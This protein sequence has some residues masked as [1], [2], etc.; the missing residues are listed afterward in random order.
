MSSLP[1]VV[2]SRNGDL[3]RYGG[4]RMTAEAFLAGADG[5]PE[6]GGAVINLCRSWRYLSKGYYVS[7]LAEARGQRVVPAPRELL[8]AQGPRILRA[9]EEA[10]V[11]TAPQEERLRR[12]GLAA[13]VKGGKPPLLVKRAAGAGYEPAPT[14]AVAEPAVLLGRC[15]DPR[16]RRLATVVFRT[17]PLPLLR[18]R[19]VREEKRWKVAAVVPMRLGHLSDEER[20]ELVRVLEGKRA[21]KLAV[22]AERPP[23][24]RAALAVLFEEGDAHLPS[25]PETIERLERVAAPLGLHVHR[26]GLRD[27][28][29]LGDYDALF[30][31]TLTGPDLPSF[32]FALQAESLGMP[33]IDDTTSILRC[34]NKVFLHELL[35]RAGLSTPPTRVVARGTKFEALTRELGRPVVLKLPDGSFASAVFRVEDEAEF[36]RRSGE[37]LERSPLILAQAYTP[38]AFDWRVTTLGGAPLFACKYHMARGHWQIAQRTGSGTH[39][40]RVEAVA[41]DDVPRAVLDLAVR[42]SCLVGGGL[43]GVDLKETPQGAVVIEVNDNPNIDLGYDDAVAGDSVY[44]ALAQHFLQAIEAGFRPGPRR[45][46]AGPEDE[47]LAGWRRPIRAPE[48]AT[49]AAPYQPFEVC[50]LELEYAVVDRD[51]NAVSRVEPALRLLAGR[52]TSDLTLG[53]FGVG[54]EYADHVLELR[55]DVPLRRLRDTEAALHEGIRRVNALL[56]DRLDARLLPTGMHPWLV[57]ARARRWTR[58]NRRIYGTYER[59][60]DTVSHGWVNVQAMH[61]NLPLGAAEADAVALINASALLVPYIPAVAASSPLVEGELTEYVD[62]RLAQLLVHQARL[63]ESTGRLV[64]EPITSL[65]E[66]KRRVVQPMYQ[67]LD[68][69]PDS[70]ALRREF[71][72]VRAAVV[73]SS[74]AALEVRVVDVQECVHMDVALAAFTRWTLRAMSERL[75]RGELEIPAHDALVKDLQATAT[76]GSRARVRAPHVPDVD[77]DAEGLADARDV[78]EALIDWA[79]EVAPEDERAYLDE[80]AEVARQGSLAERIAAALEPLADDEDQF[81]EAARRLYIELADCLLE[82]RPWAGRA[83]EVDLRRPGA[84]RGR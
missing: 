1:L 46:P 58:S 54:N 8:G 61:V 83:A 42:A 77:R 82:N 49:A 67:A 64:P 50:G 34:C 22:A 76:A 33:V 2:V 56:A 43:Y 66:Y 4:P 23:A 55:T 75:R 41:V 70:K 5:A 25:T 32:A 39:F 3:E 12:G 18:L 52:P 17:C 24:V 69:L 40:G 68:R 47:V 57:P 78:V 81:T 45:A 36:E 73:R 62:N 6:E 60:F 44:E 80:V 13:G 84:G 11:E 29:R 30:I 79:R 38:T 21:K 37:L 53:V 28:A 16:F 51:L 72:N 48:G 15:A 74:R 26:I 63:P 14:D 9:L 35:A 65:A 31:R 27:L 10:G 59:L 71:L 20:G 19:L 7:L